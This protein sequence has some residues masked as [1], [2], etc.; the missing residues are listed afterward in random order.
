M[1]SGLKSRLRAM[2]GGSGRPDIRSRAGLRV[3]DSMTEGLAGIDPPS[4]AALHRMGY[5]FALRDLSRCLFLD[6]ETT[7]FSG[8]G[9]IA[10]LVGTGW[11]E[12]TDFRL[13]QYLLG[14]Y[15]DE[16][17]MLVR[18]S[19]Q[20]R[21]YDTVVTFNGNT[22]DL[23]LLEG[24]YTMLRMRDMWVP[25][26]RMDLLPPAKKVWRR[27]LHS[28]RLANLEANI[29]RFGRE[30][31]LPGSE[32]PKRFFNYLKT[33]DAESLNPVLEHNRQ[34]VLSMALLMRRLFEAYGDP[35]A[36]TEADDLFSMG[37]TLSAQGELKTAARCYH[38]ASLPRPL[39]TIGAL[40]SER[41][42]AQALFELGLM[43]RR[44]GEYKSACSCFEKAASRRKSDPAPLIEI[45]KIE[46]HRFRNYDAALA[47]SQEALKRANDQQTRAMCEKR[48]ER[49]ERK[50]RNHTGG[51]YE[52]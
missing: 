24:R 16:P 6:T 25:L 26:R 12:G 30:D 5:D 32:A 19:E 28:V 37:K 52:P 17:E 33:G 38:L 22:F 15:P 46:E 44:S 2:S 14:D 23:P 9:T 8:A 13:R 43:H 42:A 11:F 1:A 48:I 18:L 21:A 4:D 39:V 45:A 34:D 29:L 31:D 7:G 47:L 20:M 27:R 40:R 51:D 3:I 50:I 36:Q 41:T 10:F 35:A 49:L